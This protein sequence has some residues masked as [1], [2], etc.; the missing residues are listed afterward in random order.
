MVER[1]FGRDD[2]MAIAAFRYCCGRQTY[3]VSDCVDWLIE[4]WPNIGENARRVIIRDFED[5]FRRDDECRKN[6]GDYR[7]LG[8]DCD[9]RQWE[10]VLVLRGDK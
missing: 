9:R 6:N 5:E 3:I 8:H 7:P 10:R 2:L 4:Q 1:N